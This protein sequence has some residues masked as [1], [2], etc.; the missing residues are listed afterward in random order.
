ME[1]LYKVGD[2][3][4]ALGVT[5]QSVRAW[6]RKKKIAS[7]RRDKIS[8]FRVYTQSEVDKLALLTGREIKIISVKQKENIKQYIKKWIQE[9][10]KDSSSPN[11]GIASSA[12]IYDPFDPED[13]FWDTDEEDMF[14]FIETQKTLLDRWL[15]KNTL[16]RLTPPGIV[17]ATQEYERMF[18]SNLGKGWGKIKKDYIK[19]KKELAKLK[20]KGEQ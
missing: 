19:L 10:K 6:E 12:F 2:V 18:L 1:Q 8:G 14:T 15:G 7:P 3:A 5:P 4:K 17:F 16:Y 9:S 11:S 13:R 20:T